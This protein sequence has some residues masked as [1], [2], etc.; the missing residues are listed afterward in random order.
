MYLCV[1]L[2][3][4]LSMYLCIRNEFEDRIAF[5]EE[6]GDLKTSEQLGI[7]LSIISIAI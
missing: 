5:V 4:Y 6:F 7:Y 3:I 2:S 1:Y